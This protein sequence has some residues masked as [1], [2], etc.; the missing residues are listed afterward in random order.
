MQ[1]ICT[2]SLKQ[3]ARREF[4]TA[5][6]QLRTK[7]EKSELEI[8]RIHQ[9]AS[10]SRDCL[11]ILVQISLSALGGL[12]L[13]TRLVAVVVGPPLIMEI[14]EKMWKELKKDAYT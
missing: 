8:K 2:S 14:K 11:F 6:P 12:D 10:F 1:R 9:V 4:Q 13:V 5:G 7:S 3:L